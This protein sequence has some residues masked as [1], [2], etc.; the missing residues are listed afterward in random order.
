MWI[1]YQIFIMS[2]FCKKKKPSTSLWPLPFLPTA[3][4]HLRCDLNL[5]NGCFRISVHDAVSL[6]IRF[7]IFLLQLLA[8]EVV[9]VTES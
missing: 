1:I 9:E 7:A 5:S 4:F 2:R 6:Y 3:W 8:P